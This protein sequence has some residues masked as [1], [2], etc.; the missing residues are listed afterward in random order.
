[1]KR[2]VEEQ[3][4]LSRQ[5]GFLANVNVSP[6]AKKAQGRLGMHNLI[7]KKMD[8]TGELERT[9]PTAFDRRYKRPSGRIWRRW[10]L[11]IA[12]RRRSA[13]K[14]ARRTSTR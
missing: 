1:M 12:P 6:E 7:A 9:D 14:I 13:A 4:L 2:S 10:A 5:G 8:P 11:G 3:R